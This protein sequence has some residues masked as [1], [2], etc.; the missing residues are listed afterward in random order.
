MHDI[1]YLI[2]DHLEV[3]L[4]TVI[5]VVSGIGLILSTIVVEGANL[6]PWVAAKVLLLV[7]I[8]SY[9]LRKL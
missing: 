7:G 2:M 6:G 9:I 4:S 1:L 3:K 5:L 8:G